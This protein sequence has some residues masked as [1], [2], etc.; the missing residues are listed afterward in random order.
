MFVLCECG[1]DVDDACGSPGPDNMLWLRLEKGLLISRSVMLNMA[2][3]N[4]GI[5]QFRQTHEQSQLPK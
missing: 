4:I 1:I 5:Q 3:E 2:V